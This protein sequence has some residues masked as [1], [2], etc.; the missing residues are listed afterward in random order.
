[1]ID[2]VGTLPLLRIALQV[3]IVTMHFHIVQTDLC[4]RNIVVFCC[5]FF[6][7]RGSQKTIWKPLEIVLEVQ[8]RSN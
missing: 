6:A 3:A 4:F 1:M 2:F 8:G 5:C 7:F